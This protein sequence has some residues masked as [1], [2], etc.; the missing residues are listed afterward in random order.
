VRSRSG[1]ATAARRYSSTVDRLQLSPEQ[2]RRYRDE[3]FL[4]VRGALDPA[5]DLAPL[6]RAYSRLIDALLVAIAGPERG[7]AVAGLDFADRFAALVKAGGS[8]IYSHLDPT[9]TLYERGYRHRSDLP[10]AQPPELF[11]LFRNP[12]LLD[13]VEAL[14]GPEIYATAA[15]HLNVKLGSRHRSEA[16]TGSEPRRPGG[17]S[18]FLEAF[19]AGQ[20]PWHVDGFR[21]LRD[22]GK[23]EYVTVWIPMNRCEEENGAFRVLPRSHREGYRP[24]PRHRANEAAAID[25]EPGDLVLVDGKLFHGSTA[26]PSRERFRWAF[27][28]RYVPVGS[29]TGRPYLP[30]FVARSRRAPE[31]ELRDG[32]R[33]ARYWAAALDHLTRHGAPTPCHRLSPARTDRLEALWSKQ[34][35]TP[36]DWL[37]LHETGPVHRFESAVVRLRWLAR[38][39]RHAARGARASKGA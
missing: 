24:F 28:M 32:A 26:N 30:G 34:I 13:A 36:D 25:A 8:Q 16:G 33:W 6:E 4:H 21:G 5:A 31:A 9:L 29:R 14:L 18:P 3:G 38:D 27:N 23:H 39:V 12:R 2:I 22:E 17:Q 37:R 7:A 1:G 19:Q 11:E 10:S 35:R 20:T 15:Y